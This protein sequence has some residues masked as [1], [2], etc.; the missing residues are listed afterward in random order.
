MWMATIRLRENGLK[1]IFAGETRVDRE[2]VEYMDTS[3][4]PPEYIY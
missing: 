3:F 1:P 2:N 4:F